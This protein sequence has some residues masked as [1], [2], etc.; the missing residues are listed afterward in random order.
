MILLVKCPSCGVEL[1][2]DIKFCPKCGVGIS[3]SLEGTLD[4]DYEI[5]YSPSY[6]L[7]EVKIPNNGYITAEAGAMTYMSRNIEVKTR[8]RMKESGL[9]GT[10]KVS[11]LGG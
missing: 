11:L 8:T 5:K 1:E 3:T 7:L 10:I 4:L 9:W 2:K 6:S